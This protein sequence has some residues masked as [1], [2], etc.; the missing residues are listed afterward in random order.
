MHSFSSLSSSDHRMHLLRICSMLLV[1]NLST[2]APMF[3]DTP[4]VPQDQKPM[5][6]DEVKDLLAKSECILEGKCRSKDA[7]ER[8]VSNNIYA[9]QKKVNEHRKMIDD[10]RHMIQYLVN[11]T[12]SITQFN[13][14]YAEQYSNSKPIWKSWRDVSLVAFLIIGLIGLVYILV[15]WSK[16]LNRLT[17]VL[18]RRQEKKES[19]RP[20]IAI[21][22]VQ[23]DFQR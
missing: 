21:A 10:D 9:L 6:L 14:Y 12:I 19:V 2:T 17:M 8:A 13:R 5:T 11:N 23:H 20:K 15:I 3:I 22:T 4:K 7:A 18:L 1:L 16:A